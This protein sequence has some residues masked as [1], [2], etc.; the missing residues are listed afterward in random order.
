MKYAVI[1]PITEGVL[2]KRVDQFLKSLSKT[3]RAFHL[4]L[5]NNLRD[6]LDPILKL[7]GF[8]NYTVIS[9]NYPVSYYV[10]LSQGLSLSN[11][12]DEYSICVN[13]DKGL[14]LKKD[15]LD[16]F[17]EYSNIAIGGCLY[18]YK[19]H[20]TEEDKK[21][22]SMACGGDDDLSWLEV[23][24]NSDMRIKLIDKNIFIVNNAI[25]KDVGYFKNIDFKNITDY[26]MIEFCFRFLY[27]GMGLLEVKEIFSKNSV[28]GNVFEYVDE[29]ISIAYPISNMRYRE[30]FEL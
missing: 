26:A 5:V 3:D 29:A 23:N 8:E 18:D 7:Y 22:V 2:L 13:P 14:L 10:S 21:V 25:C 15:W 20:F 17:S 4:I 12:S 9:N 24:I 28:V 11:R 19:I 16:Y 27:N 6:N 1:V 30:D